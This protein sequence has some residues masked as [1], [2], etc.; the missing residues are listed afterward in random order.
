[1]HPFALF[2]N[3]SAMFFSAFHSLTVLLALANAVAL[4]QPQSSNDKVSYSPQADLVHQF[5]YPTWVENIFVR[6]DNKLLVTILTEPEL[7]L[8]DPQSSALNPN[9]S[10]TATL[11][12]SFAPWGGLLG[13]TEVQLNHY[14]VIIS[15][16]SLLSGEFAIG[17][18]AIWSV[19]LSAYSCES[20]TGV[21]VKEIAAIANDGLL[22]GLTTLD[23]NRGLI[24]AADSVKGVIWLVNVYTGNYSILL[25]E[26]EMLPPFTNLTAGI[27]I[28]GIHIIQNG[29]IANIYFS[30]QGTAS[31][32]RIPVSVSK[33]EKVGPVEVVKSGV[34][35][36][37]FA[38]D[39][40]KG[41]AFLAGGAVNSLLK[42]GLY[43]GSLE[44]LFGGVNETVLPGPTSVA[45]GVGGE[46]N[47]AYIT[48][49]GGLM[50]SVN[51]YVEGGKVMAVDVGY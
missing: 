17:T 34:V 27:G 44:T 18:Y 28:N 42:L 16:I 51:G 37:D 5:P 8:I 39:A 23:E 3:L 50:K 43:D 25:Q 48:T 31:F 14:Y 22:N 6:R 26:P 33:L 40:E 32:Y 38:L 36:D 13:I 24:I 20:Q 1:M 29:D 35:V 15:N 45:L 9:S 7:Y 47:I 41:V 10:S 4:P 30:N 19:D 12:H 49:D 21:V 11:I 2:L 46:N